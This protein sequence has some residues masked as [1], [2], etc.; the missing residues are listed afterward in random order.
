M[1]QLDFYLL[2][3][4]VEIRNI[5]KEQVKPL[6]SAYQKILCLFAAVVWNTSV[7]DTV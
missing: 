4:L 2:W 6:I 1:C 5:Q 3:H 7:I